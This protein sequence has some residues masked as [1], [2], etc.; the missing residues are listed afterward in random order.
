MDGF[1]LLV[2][3]KIKMGMREKFIE[4]VK[5]SGI[6][7]KIKNDD[8]FIRYEYYLCE[9]DPNKLLLIEEWKSEEHQQSHMCTNH[10]NKYKLIKEKYVNDTDVKRVT[11]Q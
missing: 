3:Y 1:I 6:F 8:G 9:A 2:T 11:I 4:E 5:S 10:M 7:E